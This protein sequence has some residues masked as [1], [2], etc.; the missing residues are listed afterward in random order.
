MCTSLNC[1]IQLCAIHP[2]HY[3]NRVA[4][5]VE[6]WNRA[7]PNCDVIRITISIN[8]ILNYSNIT[9]TGY[10]AVNDQF[11]STQRK[12]TLCVTVC[13]H[14]CIV[15]YYALLCVILSL[16]QSLCAQVITRLT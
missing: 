13:C 4:A 12:V 1:D 2:M 7:L 8:Y 3:G 6:K 14:V 9:V 11:A 15:C 5:S 10:R 16:T